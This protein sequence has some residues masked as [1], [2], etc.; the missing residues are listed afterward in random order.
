VG[1]NSTIT[2]VPDKRR[3]VPNGIGGKTICH[4]ESATFH[5]HH[6]YD[7]QIWPVNALI[8]MTKRNK[9]NHHSKNNT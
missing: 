2:V 3:P 7:I 6:G 9:S 4:W 1:I 5:T 8:R